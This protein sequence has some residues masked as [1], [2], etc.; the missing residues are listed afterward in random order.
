MIGHRP[1]KVV[2]RSLHNKQCCHDVVKHDNYSVV[3]LNNCWV[4][5][6]FVFVVVVDIT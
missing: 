6:V 1:A 3:D 4:F 5:F 2:K